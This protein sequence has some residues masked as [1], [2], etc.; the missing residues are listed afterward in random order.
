MPTQM[1]YELYQAAASDKFLYI[2]PGAEHAYSY[3][4]DKEEYRRQV[5]RFLAR[6]LD[7]TLS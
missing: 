1:A 4:T 6:Y 5:T 3:V 2:V 7:H